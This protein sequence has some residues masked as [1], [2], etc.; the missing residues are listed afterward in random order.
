MKKFISV[1]IV[2][3]A[4]FLRFWDLGNNPPGI[5]V[6]EAVQGYNAY[7]LG[8]TGNDEYGKSFPIF[9]KSIGTY[10]SALYTYASIL[11][12]KLFGLTP[13]A[14]RFVSAISGVILVLLVMKYLGIVPALVIA[15]SPVF[16]F[17]S[18]GAFEP[19][20]TLT[21]F[22]LGFFL[23][24]K[25]KDKPKLLLPSF[26]LFSL[27][28]YAYR[29]EQFLSVVFIAYFSFIYL[30]SKKARPFVIFS[31]TLASVALIPLFLISLTPGGISRSAGLIVD[32]S[33]IE[34]IT[35]FIRHYLAYLSPNN[36]FSKPDPD[37]QRSFPELST[38]YW[39]FF[40]PFYRL[41]I[42][43]ITLFITHFLAIFI[44]FLAIW[45]LAK[46]LFKNPSDKTSLIS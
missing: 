32:S 42:L 22:M 38:F 27:S 41:G 20:F 25:A 19:N 10:P 39:F 6:D 29:A 31:F 34:K 30:K 21:I 14:I 24:I 35:V 36:L 8:E 33:L 15:I 16:V 17:L 37:L 7:S 4:I 18:R 12:I 11:S 44:T 40:I 1:L 2:L 23:A 13:F 45:S 3:L 46:T 9:L 28:A 5:Y 26:L 43:E